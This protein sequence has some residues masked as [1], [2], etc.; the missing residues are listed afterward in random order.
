MNALVQTIERFR[1]GQI[2]GGAINPGAVGIALLVLIL[3]TG[4]LFKAFGAEQAALYVVG[5]ALGVVLYHAAFG[6]TS[7]W[8]VFLADRRGDG[9]RAQMILLGVAS[10]LFLP[11]LAEG[12]L[13][14]R[15]IV[16]AIAP[17]SVSLLAGAF[18]FGIGMQLGGGCASGTLFTAGGGNSRMWVTLA[19]FIAGSVIA[20]LHVP[21]W[22]A[23]PKIS[24]VAL[25]RD[26]GLPAALAIQFAVF[27]AIY[28]LTLVLE[29]RRHGRIVRPLTLRADGWAALIRGPW[30]LLWGAF[31]LAALNF[32]TLGIAGHPWGITYGFTLWGAKIAA[33]LGI[34]VGAWEFWT[35]GY[36]KRALAGSVFANST[37]VMNF[38]IL[39]G[40]LLAAG[41][42]GRFAPARFWRLPWRML[43][44]AVIGGL[45][46]GYGARL[47]Y[48]C[49]IGAYFGGVASSSLHGWVWFVTAMAG[50][51]VGTWLRP[52]FD[53]EVERSPRPNGC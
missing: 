33:A 13:F 36:H 31:G 18:L 41:L 8:R 39:F 12:S 1:I 45:M 15:P 35:W 28:A 2:G 29:R 14:G 52:F 21:W 20:T 23:Q 51:A 46:M 17:L 16:G 53:M 10:L 5:G 26:F 7:A 22:F 30:P 38:G 44:A 4:S 19:A 49:N 42:A 11:A 40:A 50:S 32:A 27:G 25:V 43:A 6:F 34:D 3:G 37:S 9:L 47:A 48:G 24:S